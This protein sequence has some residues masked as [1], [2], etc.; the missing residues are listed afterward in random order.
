MLPAEQELDTSAEYDGGFGEDSPWRYEAGPVDQCKARWVR[1]RDTHHFVDFNHVFRPVT[2]GVSV[3]WP[4]AAVAVTTLEASADCEA[5]L[6]VAWDDELT[7]RLNGETVL[8]REPHRLFRR[9]EVPVR[10][11]SGGNQV[12]LKL[13][14]T[15]GTTW[16]AWCFAFRCE[17]PEGTLLVPTGLP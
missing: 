14:N 12:V 1:R 7:L 3:C 15:K 4:A 17:L 6:H 5:T 9:A 13:S 16:G 10:L 2:R 11:K 8:D